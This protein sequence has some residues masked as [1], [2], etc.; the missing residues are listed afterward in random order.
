[1][2]VPVTSASDKPQG[3]VIQQIPGA[4]SPQNQG[5]QVTIVVSQGPTE[6]PS[7]PTTPTA[8][9]T[10]S[11]SGPPTTPPPSAKPPQ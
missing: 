4:G 5:T 7:S 1:M 2:P 9:A 6:A 11:P 10:L 8:T 3:E